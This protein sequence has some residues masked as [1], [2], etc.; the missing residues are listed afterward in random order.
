VQSCKYA[1]MQIK[2]VQICNYANVQIKKKLSNKV[3]LQIC[4]FSY[5]LIVFARALGFEPR[6]RVL[7]TRMLAVAPCPQK[8]T[9][10]IISF[11][12]KIVRFQ[13]FKDLFLN[14]SALKE[15]S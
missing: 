5:C 6:S 2:N 13:Y 4:I 8:E 9:L 11:I 7:E 14:L 15:S 10:F 3:H 12:E 1:N